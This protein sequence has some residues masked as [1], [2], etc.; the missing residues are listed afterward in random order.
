MINVLSADMI[1]RVIF[2]LSIHHVRAI[3]SYQSTVSLWS[4]NSCDCL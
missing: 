4:I 1:S 3:S 2:P